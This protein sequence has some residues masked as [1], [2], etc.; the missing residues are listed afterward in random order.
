MKFN[1]QLSSLSRK[2]C[3]NLNIFFIAQIKK[4]YI[5]NINFYH[6][7]I[8]YGS[9]FLHIRIQWVNLDWI[10]IFVFYFW[11]LKYVSEINLKSSKSRFDG[12]TNLFAL[13]TKI[14]C[15]LKIFKWKYHIKHRN[16]EPKNSLNNSRPA[17]TFFLQ[18]KRLS[19]SLDLF[20]LNPL[21]V[22]PLVRLFV[23]ITFGPMGLS[24]F[25]RS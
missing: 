24:A 18:D 25:R 20:P 1:F 11:Y 5:I 7:Y 6:F 13:F 16:F 10:I 12:L 15:K 9:I 23:R 14:I 3:Q 22:G 17:T 19:F 21:S 4:V 8:Q 2:K